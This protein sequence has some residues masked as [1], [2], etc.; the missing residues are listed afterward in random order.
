MTNVNNKNN[1]VT[2]EGKKNSTT[3]ADVK[4]AYYSDSS[5]NL[6]SR[7]LK[8]LLVALLLLVLTVPCK[9]VYADNPNAILSE[10]EIERRVDEAITRKGYG[11]DEFRLPKGVEKYLSEETKLKIYADKGAKLIPLVKQKWKDSYYWANA[12]NQR[13]LTSSKPLY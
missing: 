4:K 13:K 5:K 12:R 11:T 1:N 7:K 9:I 6:A 3:I 2:A 10:K 8:M